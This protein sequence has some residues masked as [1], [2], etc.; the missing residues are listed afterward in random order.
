MY[1]DPYQAESP[2]EQDDSSVSSA[3]PSRFRQTYRSL[4]GNEALLNGSVAPDFGGN[5]S[6]K[7]AESNM[8]DTRINSHAIG[9]QRKYTCREDLA[10]YYSEV[11]GREELDTFLV[12]NMGLIKTLLLQKHF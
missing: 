8:Y 5:R 4:Q 10:A 11:E 9:E 12:P 2:M 1:L 3:S 6:S 7:L